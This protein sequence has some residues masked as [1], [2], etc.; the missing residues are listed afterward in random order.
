MR[1]ERTFRSLVTAVL[2]PKG[3]S[4]RSDNLRLGVTFF[5]ISVNLVPT[6]VVAP[7]EPLARMLVFANHLIVHEIR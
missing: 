1:V 6:D 7:K 2:S 3:N 5:P 4:Q